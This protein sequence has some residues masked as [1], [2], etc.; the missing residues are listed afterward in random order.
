MLLEKLAVDIIQNQQIYEIPHTE[1]LIHHRHGGRELLDRREIHPHRYLLQLPRTSVHD[2]KIVDLVDRRFAVFP[3]PNNLLPHHYHLH[4]L[5]SQLDQQ[6]FYQ[7]SYHSVQFVDVLIEQ[8][9]DVE[10]VLDPHLQIHLLRLF[11]LLLAL[12][13][14][15]ENIQLL[16]NCGSEPSSINTYS[17]EISQLY[18]SAVVTLIRFLEDVEGEGDDFVAPNFAGNLEIEAVAHENRW[19]FLVF[20]LDLPD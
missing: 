14:Y 15:H 16:L 8:A 11:L 13:L 17:K 18:G 7:A 5:D 1:L 12:V 2:F 9:V 20:E 19:L 6:K 4:L 3:D 10:A